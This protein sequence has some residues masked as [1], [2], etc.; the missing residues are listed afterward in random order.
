MTDGVP[1][2]Y[3]AAVSRAVTAVQGPAN[4]A[5][6][7]LDAAKKAFGANAWTG[8]TSSSFGADLA[9]HT[10]VARQSAQAAVADLRAIHDKEPDQVP[11]G[12]WQLRWRNL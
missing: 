9:G 3:K 4:A 2:P 10:T 1:N 7:A 12:A 6:T 11:P 5:A 8:G